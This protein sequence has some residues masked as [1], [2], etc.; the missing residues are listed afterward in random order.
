M[1]N[2]LAVLLIFA[3]VNSVAAPAQKTVDISTLTTEQQALIVEQ[4]GKLSNNDAQK[5]SATIRAE[6]EAWGELGSNMG[7]AMVGAAKELGMAANDFAQTPL[8]KIAVVTIAYKLVGRDI[9]K[10]FYGTMI[11][12]FGWSI[13]V[14]SFVTNRWSDVKYEYEPVFFGMFKKSRIISL[15]SS[16]DLVFGKV[17]FGMVCIILSTVVGMNIIL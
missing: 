15:N 1:K 9:L 12:I 10:V 6:T 11:L 7:R 2:F 17:V 4:V 16:S 14:F 3:C 8:G 5:T 13:G